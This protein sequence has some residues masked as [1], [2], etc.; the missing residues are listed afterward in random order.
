MAM[1]IIARGYIQKICGSA[2]CP[3]GYFGSVVGGWDL[4]ELGWSKQRSTECESRFPQLESGT[5]E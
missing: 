4:D 3:F 5:K 1:L 2:K